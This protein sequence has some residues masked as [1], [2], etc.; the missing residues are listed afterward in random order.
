MKRKENAK[1]GKLKL[2]KVE[3]EVENGI[4]RGI[5]KKI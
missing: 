2:I 5:K 4:K 1:E 3:G